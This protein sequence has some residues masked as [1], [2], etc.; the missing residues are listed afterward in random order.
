MATAVPDKPALEGLEEKWSARWKADNTY[1]FD[2]TKTREQIYSVDTPPPTVSGH[3]HIGSVC[4]YT[5]TDLMVRYK[6]MSGWEV[7]YPMGWDD[8]GL[9]IERRTQIN[10]GVICNPSMPY[11]PNFEPP[12]KPGKEPIPV[13]RPNF[14]ELCS[15][16]TEDLEEEFERLWRTVGLSVD[17]NY[18]YRTI[19]SD[20]TRVSQAAFLRLVNQG[21]AF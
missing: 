21:Q 4:S 1:A 8:N 5:H 12:A 16:L 14:V 18:L 7:F 6:R 9:N 11:D 2:R 10:Y 3:L 15:Q 17:W 20:V 19:G 13:S